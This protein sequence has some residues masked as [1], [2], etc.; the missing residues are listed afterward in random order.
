MSEFFIGRLSAICYNAIGW[1]AVNGQ[2]N[3]RESTSETGQKIRLYTLGLKR[4]LL[5]DTVK[6][7]F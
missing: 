3:D 2:I 7:E 1:S 6:A 4:T 5:S